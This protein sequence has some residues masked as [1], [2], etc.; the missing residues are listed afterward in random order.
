MTWADHV[1][2]NSLERQRRVTLGVGSKQVK[3]EPIPCLQNRDLLRDQHREGILCSLLL[4]VKI[5]CK[6]GQYVV[7]VVDDG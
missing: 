5:C 3:R 6:K 4:T 1:V 2:A 7:D